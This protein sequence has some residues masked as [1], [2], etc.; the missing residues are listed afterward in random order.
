MLPHA[1]IRRMSKGDFWFIVVAW[2]LLLT[3]VLAA[4]LSRFG[5]DYIVRFFAEPS[6]KTAL[7]LGLALLPLRFVV[8]RVARS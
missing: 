3:A 8:R 6:L 5:S 7:F 4:G 2:Y 1:T